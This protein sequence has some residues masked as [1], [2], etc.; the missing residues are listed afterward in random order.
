MIGLS[1]KSEVRLS[2]RILYTNTGR[3]RE[4]ETETEKQESR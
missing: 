3:K 4:P 1:S 2:Q